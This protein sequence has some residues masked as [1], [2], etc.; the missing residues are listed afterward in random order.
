MVHQI[1]GS[2]LVTLC[3]LGVSL[4]VL[5]AGSAGQAEP[6]VLADAHGTRDGELEPRYQPREPE[7]EPA[8]N[9]E[10]LFAMT[11]GVANSTIHPA[12]Q[13]PLFLFTVPLDIALLPFAAIGGLF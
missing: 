1:V 8:Y 7:P 2:S 12:G 13:L 4:P 10:Y 5:A 11:R 6:I 9:S 3:L